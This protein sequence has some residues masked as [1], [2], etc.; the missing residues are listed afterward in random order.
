M[1]RRWRKDR[2]S[3]LSELTALNP[4]IELAIGD[5]SI[6]VGYRTNGAASIY[7]GQDFVV[8]F[9]AR[10]E[11]RRVFLHGSLFRAESG[12]Q[13]GAYGSSPDPSRVSELRSEVLSDM[14]KNELLSLIRWHVEM[15]ARALAGDRYR[16][17]G[18]YP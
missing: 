7:F 5:R 18:S 16:I 14:A 8:G 1:I 15:L 4:R 2:R 11:V 10:H 17:L 9:N 6:L 3:L 12:H 13:D